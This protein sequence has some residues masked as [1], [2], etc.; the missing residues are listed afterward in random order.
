[1]LLARSLVFNLLFYINLI[2]LMILGMPLMLA[3]PRGVIWL[4]RTWGKT[5][6]WLLRA[7]CGLNVEYRGLRNIPAGGY[8]IAPKHQ[9]IWETFAL[10]PLFGDFTFIVKRE[11]TW[12]PLFGW[13]LVVARQIAINRASGAAAL[14]EATERATRQLNSARPGFIFPEGTRRPAGA[15]P[16]YKF[17][18]AAIYAASGAQCLPIALNSGL[19]W[20]RRSFSRRP[21]TVLVEI[22][23]PIPAGLER[24]AFLE[25][26]TARLE[27]ATNRLIAEAIRADA[28]LGVNLENP[29]A[30]PG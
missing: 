7:I 23:E 1:M 19:F 13:Y 29:C 24:Q 15:P 6:L 25:T 5:S 12:I 30:E 22:L 28:T 11:L 21:G 20:P 18:V 9:S 3:G 26:L 4:A 16:L 2:G 10:L 8:I 14:S 27:G 17:G